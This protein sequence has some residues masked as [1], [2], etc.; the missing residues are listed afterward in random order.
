MSLKSLAVS[1][2]QLWR[3]RCR[4]GKIAVNPNHTDFPALLAEA[5]DAAT[6]CNGDI[7]TTAGQLECTTSQLIKF[8]KLEPRA[9]DKLNKQR[10]A[11]GGTPLR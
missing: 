7:K 10:A 9:L 6:A 3:S 5:L 11:D 4:S 2:S 8:F 1:P